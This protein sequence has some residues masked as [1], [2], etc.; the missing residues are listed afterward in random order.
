MA[1]P[2]TVA[3]IA[4]GAG[5]L[6]SN[7]YSAWKNTKS[8]ADT[9]AMNY[10]IWQE[11]LAAQK[12]QWKQEQAN[13]LQNRRWQ[14]QDQQSERYWNSVQAQVARYRAAGLNPALAMYG[15]AGQNTISTSQATPT[16]PSF[17]APVS[18]SQ[19]VAPQIDLTGMG[20]GLQNGFNLYLNAKRVETDIAVAKQHADNESIKVASD[21]MRNHVQNK[22]TQALLNQVIQ[23]TRFDQ[24][25]WPLR[26]EGVRLANEAIKAD[27]TLK[28]ESAK[29]QRIVN[30]FKPKEQQKILRNLDKQ[31]D[32]IDSRI[33]LNDADGAYKAALKGLSDAQAE[34]V[35]IDNATKFEMAESIV[36]QKAAEADLADFNAQNAGRQYTE[37]KLGTYMPSVSADG[38]TRD[39]RNYRSRSH[40][41]P[42]KGSDGKY[43]FKNGSFSHSGGVR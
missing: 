24:E 23:Q 36:A 25:A 12:Q 20:L 10:R 8:Q 16:E 9:N 7:V 6:I 37:G 17:S 14:L 35:N 15:G 29:T 19:M 40:R 5:N 13:Y 11:Q 42:Y 34:G 26:F 31:A 28:Q 18:A 27:T 21:A 22:H 33:R 2:A 43:H 1:D 3:G 41:V 4:V 39:Y 32:E 38:S 30:E